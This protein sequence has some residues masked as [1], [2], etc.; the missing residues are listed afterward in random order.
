[1][2]SPD[3]SQSWRHAARPLD[4]GAHVFT[5]D[6]HRLG[7]VAEVDPEYFKLDVSLKPD[8]WLSRDAVWSS[9]LSG[10]HV[11]FP[12]SDLEQYRAEAPPSGGG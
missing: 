10:V 8:Y 3:I 5:L 9:D 2:P 11:R 1:M 6:G 12:S 4:V 7:R